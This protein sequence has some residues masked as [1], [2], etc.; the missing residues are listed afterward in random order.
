MQYHIGTIYAGGKGVPRDPMKALE[1]YRKAAEQD[2]TDS[3]LALGLLQREVRN[4]TEAMTW[5]RVA[6]EK[7]QAQVQAQA[8]LHIGLMYAHGEGVPANQRKAQKWFHKAISNGSEEAKK[9]I[10]R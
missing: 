6:A 1:W 5:L 9:H 2:H 4:F 10:K 8:Q 3:E 7:S